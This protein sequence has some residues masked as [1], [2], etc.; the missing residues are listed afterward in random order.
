MNVSTKES[1]PLAT[2]FGQDFIFLIDWDRL[3]LAGLLG[4]AG[5]LGVWAVGRHRLLAGPLKV[6]T[7][8]TKVPSK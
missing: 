1:K 7:Y 4:P 8:Y 6:C 2:C 3:G 5:L